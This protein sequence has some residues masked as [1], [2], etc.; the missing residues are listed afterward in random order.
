SLAGAKPE[1]P[2]KLRCEHFRSVAWRRGH[3]EF[4]SIYG[5]SVW[6]VSVD[7]LGLRL[8]RLRRE[9]DRS[10]YGAKS[11]VA[12]ALDDLEEEQVLEAAR[13]GLEV[14][15]RL[16]AVAELRKPAGTATYLKSEIEQWGQVAR[17]NKIEAPGN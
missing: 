16:V 12:A 13:I 11:L 2:P 17:D 1:S 9:P 10:V 4:D 14:F 5:R 6:I 7:V 3:R 15:A 8:P